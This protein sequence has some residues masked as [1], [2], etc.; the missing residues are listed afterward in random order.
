MTQSS[1]AITVLKNGNTGIGADT[2]SAKLEVA[3]Q[4]KITGGNPA[5]GKVLTSDA[6]GLA[7]WQNAASGPFS[8]SG[9]ITRNSPITD[10]LV[11]GSSSLEDVSGTAD[12]IRLFFNKTKGAFRA[13]RSTTVEWNDASVGQFSAAFGDNNKASGPNSFAS[14][15]ASVASG[16]VATAIGFYLNA[17]AMLSTAVGSYNVG[18]GTKD[19][20]V[21]TDPIFE[22]GNGIPGSAKS[23]AVTVLKNGS[24]GIG[25]HTPSQKLHIKG[26]AAGNA[27]LLIEPNKWA[28]AGDYG[29]VRFGDANHYIRGEHT[30]GMTFY[31]ADKF[32]FSGGK[33]GIGTATP[34]YKLDVAGDRIRLFET[35]TSDWI[36]LRTDGGSND[37]LDFSWGGGSLVMQGAA[38]NE[39]IIMNPSMNRVGIRTWT[40][41]YDL[42]VNGNI[43]ATGSVYYG[44]TTTTTGTAYNKPDYVFGEDYKALQTG[45]IEMFLKENNHLPWV[46]SAEKE[47]QENGEATDMT[48]MAFETLE[49]VENLQLQ[50]ISQQKLIKEQH[51]IIE[52]LQIRLERIE[53]TLKTPK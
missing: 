30:A 11:F 4:M 50:I 5:A 51:E 49:S 18:S 33:V 26:S 7:S 8:S 22:I 34:A 24:T 6:N 35:T 53:K 12:D 45:E 27:V 2:P 16:S 10:H 44:G 29:E 23:N 40:P 19:S 36:A 46:T 32:N 38:T 47:K 41:Q 25:T 37:Y 21:E 17:T 28:G 31:D 9:G 1:N 39:N 52:S 13:G 3:G 48:R 42:D 15:V 14:G 20:W 43:R